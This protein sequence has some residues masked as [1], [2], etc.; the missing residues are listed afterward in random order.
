MRFKV[1]YLADLKCLYP[2]GKKYPLK[3]TKNSPFYGAVFV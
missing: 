1:K 3:T 2:V